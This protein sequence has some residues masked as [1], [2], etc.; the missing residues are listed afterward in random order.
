[1]NP[2]MNPKLTKNEAEKL[3]A[4]RHPERFTDYGDPAAATEDKPPGTAAAAA[5]VRKKS[6]AKARGKRH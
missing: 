5:A 6:A 4:I 2:K 3:A 1:M